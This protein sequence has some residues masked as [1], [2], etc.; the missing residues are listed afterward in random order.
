MDRSSNRQRLEDEIEYLQHQEETDTK[1]ILPW[2][3][4]GGGAGSTMFNNQVNAK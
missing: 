2:M 1:K 4:L 3:L